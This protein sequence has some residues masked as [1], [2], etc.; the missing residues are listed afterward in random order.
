MAKSSRDKIDEDI[1]LI[2]NEIQKNANKSINK[3]AYKLGFSRQKV[4]RIINDLEKDKT[5]WGYTTIIDF[6][7]QDLKYFVIL[8]KRSNKPLDKKLLDK[9]ISRDLEELLEQMG[10][11]LV[12]SIYVNGA[13]DWIISITCKSLIDAKKVSELIHRRYS[14]YLKKIDLLQGLF[15]CKINYIL[16]P[17]IKNLSEIF[18][19]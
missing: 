13:Y 5:I 6:T 4:W 18:K 16:N 7:K 3:I 15:P 2:L 10:C 14:D 12:S 8:A 19:M 11:K 1:K 17:N 9:V